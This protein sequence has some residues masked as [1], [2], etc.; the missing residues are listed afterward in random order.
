MSRDAHRYAV[1]VIWTGNRG[2]GTKTYTSYGR[3]HEIHI[4]GKPVIAGSSDAAFRGDSSK[5]N[6]EDMLVTSLSTCHMLW[7]LHLV[8]DAGVVVTDYRDHAEG[9]LSIDAEHGGRFTDVVLRPVVTVSAQ[10]DAARA[11]A[12]HEDAHHACYVARSMNFPVR[13]EPRILTES[14]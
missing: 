2:L 12:V 11:A 6:P 5:H 13:C 14:V 1:D 4:A 8:S 3:E 7:Y 9:L 10:S